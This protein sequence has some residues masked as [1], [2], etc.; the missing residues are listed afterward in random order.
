MMTGLMGTTAMAD[1][2]SDNAP[3]IA[4]LAYQVA[5]NSEEL[6]YIANS[7]NRRGPNF[8]SVELESSVFA[9]NHDD[10]PVLE[11]HRHDTLRTLARAANRMHYAASDLY[12]SARRAGGR[13]PGGI[14]HEDHAG[15]RIRADFR[16]V[17]QQWR[18]VSR[19]Y[20]DLARYGYNYRITR[21][22]NSLRYSMRNLN[23]YAGNSDR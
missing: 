17:Q 3:A 8:E 22:Y 15:D 9:E 1:H 7:G 6:A 20:R 12:R 16:R 4:R 23:R 5:D 14:H 2:A 13:R 10:G 21:V 19:S 18:Q 11:D